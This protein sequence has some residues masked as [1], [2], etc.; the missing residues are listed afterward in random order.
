MSNPVGFDFCGVTD[1]L[2]MLAIIEIDHVVVI[3]AATLAVPAAFPS[4]LSK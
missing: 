4:M 3:F 2:G 1:R